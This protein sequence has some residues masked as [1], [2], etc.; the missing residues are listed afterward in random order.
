MRRLPT[1]AG[2]VVAVATTILLLAGCG[3]SDVPVGPPREA[4]PPTTVVLP[5]VAPLR[6]LT[7]ETVAS[8]LSEPVAIAPAPGIDET[9][10]VERTGSIVTASSA[11]DSKVLDLTAL[12]AWEV[13]EQGLLGFAVHPDFPDDPRGFAV[14]TN[15]SFDVVVSEFTWIGERFDPASRTQVLV[16]PQPHKYHQ[17]GG[18]GFDSAGNLWLSFG[19][20]GGIGDRYG[21]GQDPT[22]LNG[23]LVRID[24]DNGEPYA[25]PPG[26]P[27]LG[28]DEGADEVW[29]YGLRNPWRFAID[30][31]QVVIAD[32]G[33]YEAEEVNVVAADDGGYNFG[34]PVMEADGCFDATEC[35]DTGMTGPVLTLPHE[36]LC[37]I[38][39]GP[40]YRGTA[41]P[42]LH[43]HYVF[44]DHCVGWVRS[45]PLLEGTLGP[46]T[47]WETDL[48][49]LGHITSIGIDHDGELLVANLEGDLLRILPVRDGA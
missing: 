9:F 2:H 14:Y 8:D 29:A 31:D 17:G 34:W 41:I 27:W 21:N 48:G 28:S 30:G 1:V 46:V 15:G 4:P 44:G 25:I 45:A 49:Q 36:R 20:G 47:D 11:G 6:S 33:Q 43:G 18:I 12:I 10:I 24:V 23:T 32:V 38:I 3:T 26:N 35:D 37:A 13:N 40:V 5:D 19:D 7:T 42:E 22:T 16:V 39:G